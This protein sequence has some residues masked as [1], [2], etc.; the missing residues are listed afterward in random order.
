MSNMP[1]SACATPQAGHDAFLDVIDQG[2][3]ECEDTH[4]SDDSQRKW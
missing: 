3:F 4:R 2:E 1:A